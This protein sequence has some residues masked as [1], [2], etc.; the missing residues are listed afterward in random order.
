M[1]SILRQEKFSD[2]VFVLVSPVETKVSLGRNKSFNEG[3][4]KFLLTE[5]K[6]S[7]K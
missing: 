1:T 7:P 2:S 5:T 6:V 4:Q 3:K